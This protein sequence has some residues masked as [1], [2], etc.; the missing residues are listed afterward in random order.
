MCVSDVERRSWLWGHCS[1]IRVGSLTV[2]AIS[3]LGDVHV[4]RRRQDPNGIARMCGRRVHPRDGSGDLRCSAFGDPNRIVPLQTRRG[5]NLRLPSGRLGNVLLPPGITDVGDPTWIETLRV[6]R[7]LSPRKT[8]R[9]SSPRCSAFCDPIRIAPLRR[10]GLFRES[11]QVPRDSDPNGIATALS[12]RDG[13]LKFAVY[14]VWL[15][16]ILAHLACGD[17]TRIAVCREARVHPLMGAFGK[18]F[19]GK[20][21][22]VTKF[23]VYLQRD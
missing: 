14:E 17:P 7:L 4:F 22:E 9:Q 15:S 13:H 6:T 10:T 2:A 8:S 21:L 3:S 5:R 12:S 23:F 11:G 18:N 16:Q 20:C 1:A 19:F